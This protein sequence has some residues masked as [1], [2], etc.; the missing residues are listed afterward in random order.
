MLLPSTRTVVVLAFLLHNTLAFCQNPDCPT[1][2]F[3]KTF[4]TETHTEYGSVLTRSGDGNLYLAGR[5]AANTFIQKTS[6]AG[7]VIWMREFRI[8]PF[9]PVTPIQI[10]ED[11]EGMIVGCGTQIQFAGASRGFVFRYDPVAN[12]FLWA[13]PISSSNPLAAGILEKTPGGSF[14]YYQNSVLSDGETDIEILDL[15]RVTGNIIPAF[16]SRYEHISYD[17]LVKMVTVNG[18]L[19]GLGSVEG[20][21]SFDNSAR[22]LMLA[23]FDP[24]N[25]MPIWAQ[26]S[27]DNTTAQTDFLARDLLV[28]GD[29]LLAAYV[30]DEDV[31]DNP[32][33]QP[34]VIH[35]QKTDLDGNILWIKRYAWFTSILRVISVPDGYVLSGQR[36]FNSK[37]FVFKVNKNGDFVW[38]RNLDYGPVST[39]N[40]LSHGP[41]Q[42]VAVA[43]SLYFTGLATTGFGDVLFW[44]MLADGTMADSCGYV[45]NLVLEVTD[46]QNPVKTPINLQQLLSTA[47]AANSNEPWTTNTLEEHLV[48]PDCSVPNPCPEGNDFVIDINNISCSGGFINMSLS[49]CELAGGALPDLSITF[50][51]AN[52]YTEAAD[53][54]AVYDFSS[55]NSDSCAT[56]QLTNLD[57]LFGSNAVQNGL[58]IFAVVND[59]GNTQTPFLLDDFPLSDLEECNYFN[60][61]DSITVQLPTAPTLNLG[62]DQSIC[63]NESYTI[64]AGPG[65][66]KYQWSN[67]ASTQSTTVSFAGQYRVTVTDA[68]GFRQFDTVDIQVKQIPLV[69]DNGEFCPGKSVT[70][71]G[72]TFD[73]VGTFQEI[74]PGIN[75]D[76]DTSATITISQLPYE[77]RIE[78]IHFCPYETVT[79]N[80]IVY[81]DSGLVR[82]TVASATTCDTIVF[83]FLDELPFPFRTFHFDICPGDSV[84]FNGQVYTDTLSFTDTL[85]STGAGC[86][87]VAFVS[88]GFLQH[89]ELNQTIQFCPGTSVEID[90]QSYNQPGTVTATLP[91]TTGGC[92]TLV[93][94]T[95]EHLPLL[96]RAETVAFCPGTS[97][98]IGGQSYTQP[99]TV[100]L[101]LPGTAGGC[102]T[103]VT[104]TLQ[105]APLPARSET[106]EFCKGESITLG[107]QTYTQPTTVT[108][109]ALGTGNNC[110]TLVTYT[111]Q[112]LTPPPSSMS[113]VCPATVNVAT[114]PGTGPIPVT[115]SA[116]V[117]TSNCVCPGNALSLTSG[118][119]SGGLFPVGNTQVCYSAK[120]S[121]GSVA[122]CC[123][124][125]TVR[126]ELPCDTK[127][128]G[129][130]KYELLSITANAE[131]ERTYKIRVTNSC[132]NKLIYTA[133][134]LPDG[135]SAV[136]P[137]NN[138]TYTSPDGRAYTVRN[139]NYSPFYSIRFKSVTDSI[140]NGQSDVLTYTLPAQTNPTFI[141]I[142]TRLA[143]QNFYAAHLNT[144]NCPIG[145]TPTSNRNAD[146]D[147]TTFEKLSNL[148]GILLFPNPTNGE[149]F[150]DLSQWQGQDLNIQILDSRGMRTQSFSMNAS[151]EAQ[152]I[153]LASQLPSGLYFLEIVT[154][155]GEREV[156]RFV[157]ER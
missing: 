65:F 68:C 1:P 122:N 24:V 133:I 12:L 32:D 90:G 64:N 31:N 6:L 20:R 102:D 44:K 136:S 73:Q 21:D 87:T 51:N 99:G 35:L 34:N 69:L 53:K 14:V 156:E 96:T 70:V 11:S 138:S 8:S 47:Q 86:D 113:L 33:T 30:V 94:Y 111:L 149:L 121:C 123:F 127:T 83:Y 101:T 84:T 135:F 137:A 18:S 139:P 49:I 126:E 52:P 7:E 23:R 92:D 103:I 25:G 77:E 74:I 76:C 17:V 2:T 141:N 50:Y 16:A 150:A 62:A 3:F 110:D 42:S 80:G 140:A 10:F 72:F 154:E 116:P 54:V 37:Y 109:T 79:I 106:L 66:F 97:V 55:S 15:E 5:N 48:C 157:L 117:A 153:P 144:F 59:F 108:L 155:N 118:A 27:H 107:G 26:L 28:D 105:F 75:G 71:R 152:Q 78:V 128:N 119:A 19:Y 57:N 142:T 91:S 67:G 29:A 85:Y 146:E 4:G 100:I 125:V 124:I 148:G 134:Q 40:T 143:T 60:N 89:V 104:Y 131:K 112:F 63:S 98:D 9:E 61:L 81:E 39:P 147:L 145:V 114:T 58:Q 45:E 115:Y 46:V 43:D 56:V 88:I 82:D 93:T 130:I 13:H 151:S 38:G 41:D 132:A 129:C 95:L 22:R 36:S 120:D